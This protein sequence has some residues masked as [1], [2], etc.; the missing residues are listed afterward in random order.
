MDRSGSMNNNVPSTT[1]TKFSLLQTSIDQFID[2]FSQ[3]STSQPD[4]RIALIWF[5]SGTE[6]VLVNGTTWTPRSGWASV[7]QAVNNA[8]AGG[9][10]AMGDG[11]SQGVAAWT[12]DDRHDPMLVLFTDGMQNTGNEIEDRPPAGDLDYYDL[13]DGAYRPLRHRAIPMGVIGIGVQAAYSGILQQISSETG[14]DTYFDAEQGAG[15][16]YAYHDQL[17]AAL[18]GNTLSLLERAQSTLL[19]GQQ[20]YGP[21]TMSVGK[22][23]PQFICCLY[24]LG[25]ENRAS[26][27]IVFVAPDGSRT[28]PD[29]RADGLYYITQTLNNPEP[30]QWQVFVS[31]SREQGGQSQSAIPFYLSAMV[32]EG[33]FRMNLRHAASAYR[34]GEEI[35]LVLEF[36]EGGQPL[37]LAQAHGRVTCEILGPSID[38]GT[39]LHELSMLNF[40]QLTSV[41]GEEFVDIDD[42][43]TLKLAYY[44]RAGRLDALLLPD[45]GF[46]FTFEFGQNVSLPEDVQQGN[47]GLSIRYAQTP[48]PG[49]YRCRVLVELETEVSGRV[50]RRTETTLHLGL[51]TIDPERS[52]VRAREYKTRLSRYAY[53]NIQVYDRLG[54]MLGPGYD[55]RIDVQAKLR[56]G[57]VSYMTNLNATSEYTFR[58]TGLMQD[59][60]PL[61]VI[62]VFDQVLRKAL[63][64]ELVWTPPRTPPWWRKKLTQYK[65]RIT[66]RR[67]RRLIN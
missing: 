46:R 4:D 51:A 49:T 40:D 16:G 30:G 18:K 53:L 38:V 50:V 12:N 21:I 36:E 41:L 58:I 2:T 10:T 42:P 3:E 59:E 44:N 55:D 65:R 61:I 7:Q 52:I 31:R 5:S 1:T 64:S 19:A 47:S 32:S 14:G 28:N 45:R 20:T 13:D 6:V 8:T 37:S 67:K 29:Q 11:V 35:Y 54:N 56:R 60:D 27:D 23:T 63:L 33:P 39:Y 15:I 48:H 34:A 17:I 9:N 62:R 25:L 24:W 26:L 66:Q 43:L 57:R 22:D